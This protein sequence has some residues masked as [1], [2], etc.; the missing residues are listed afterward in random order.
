MKESSTQIKY[1]FLL[2]LILT[3]IQTIYSF[4]IINNDQNENKL[5]EIEH[6]SSSLSLENKQTN[7]RECLSKN[8]LSNIFNR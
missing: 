2:V 5:D 3:I 8:N 6:I 4:D 7:K 1:F